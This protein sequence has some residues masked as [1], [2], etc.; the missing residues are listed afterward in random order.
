MP[1]D[2]SLPAF[3]W[4]QTSLARLFINETR[5]PV[6][7]HLLK[8]VNNSSAQRTLS[9]YLSSGGVRTTILPENFQL[10][11]GHMASDDL[12]LTL[13]N[14]DSIEG[15]TDAEGAVTYVIS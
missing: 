6:Q 2:N 8:L 3:G 1:L 4:L 12:T 7:I 10:N 9:I 13:R 14:N 11:A 15:F 5:A